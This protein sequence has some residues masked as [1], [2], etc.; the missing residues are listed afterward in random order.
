MSEIAVVSARKSQLRHN[1]KLGSKSAISALKLAED[2]DKFLSTVQIGITLIGILTGIYSGATLAGSFSLVLESIYVPHQYSFYIAQIT[3]IIIVTYL[4]IVFGELIPKK[5]GLNSASKVA[6]IIA[7]PMHI[8]SAIASPFVWLLSSSTALIFKLTGLKGEEAQVTEEEIRSMIKEGTASGEVQDVE[9]NI[10]ERV[11]SLGDR[12]IDSLM[13]YRHDIIWIDAHMSNEQIFELIQ[14]NLC[15]V[16]PIANKNLDN[17]I[18]T[19]SLKDL[20]G[21]I[22]DPNFDI[23]QVIRPALFLHVKTEVYKALDQMKTNHSHYAIVCD[24]F[25]SI[26]GIVTYKDILEGLIG[27]LPDNKNEEPPIIQRQDGSYLIDGQCDF[28]HFLQYFDLESLYTQYKHNTIAGL[29]I[30]ELDRIPMSG[31]SFQ[32]RNFTIEIV[33]MDGPRIDKLLVSK[34]G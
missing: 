10:L 29:V 2:P 14:N 13:T 26:E 5:I 24:E 25:G 15:K 20:F 11:F 34:K 18:G 8:L 19:V 31:E 30:E 23:K 17:I 6:Q 33:D 1:A 4:S 9:Q 12:T 21:K 27:D 7:K 22:T 3:I 28:Y 32:W 16:Y